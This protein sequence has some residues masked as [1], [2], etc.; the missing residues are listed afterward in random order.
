MHKFDLL[1]RGD[2]MAYRVKNE[3]YGGMGGC[4]SSLHVT[5]PPHLNFMMLTEISQKNDY[6]C[7]WA[8]ALLNSNKVL[9]FHQSLSLKKS[10]LLATCRPTEESYI[11]DTH[12]R[13]V[14]EGVLHI[15]I[16]LL[17]LSLIIYK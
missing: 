12:R 2:W 15:A 7:G 9:C 13:Y 17:M 11:M 10:L 8:E 3:Y 14:A 1:L 6:C 16:Y 4:Y 5:T